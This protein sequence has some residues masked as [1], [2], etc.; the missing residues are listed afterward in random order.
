MTPGASRVTTTDTTRPEPTRGRTRAVRI[1]RVLLVAGA[2]LASFAAVADEV[3][4]A[5]GDRLTG[6]VVGK[7][8]G[9]LILDTAWAGEVKVRWDDV[10]SLRTDADVA[11][12]IDGVLV[13][14]R[15]DVA[16][17]PTLPTDA[18]SASREPP[19][20]AATF[21]RDSDG[22]ARRVPLATITF[23]NPTHAE[24]GDGIDWTGRLNTSGTFTRGNT[25][26][27]RFYGEG[28]LGGRS[29]DWRGS[30]GARGNRASE[31]SERTVSN[32]LGYADLDRFIDPR[33]YLYTRG[34]LE[35]DVF[36]DI[37]LRTTLGAGY[38]RQWIDT[39]ATQF[40]TQAGLDYLNVDR[41]AGVVDSYPSVGWGAKYTQWLLE[42]RL[43]LFHDQ[44]GFW[45]FDDGN[46]VTVRTRQ[47]LRMPVWRGF[48]LNVQLNVD[49]ESRPAE[50]RRA[51]DRV[52][53][54]GVGYQW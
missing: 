51:A 32:A 47:G 10:V 22:I 9:K 17:D 48:T 6:R 16:T 11:I 34:S 45:G 20:P 25:D 18:A 13:R 5:N 23:M 39:S 30:V 52:W 41:S 4:L 7:R 53:V 43:Q 14:G 35:S 2:A 27:T 46:R 44:T 1:A 33:R 26:A 29:K 19:L 21:T 49:W 12:V 40:S 28:E 54:F 24:S 3:R 50:G 15:L 42:R 36:R 8:D 38:G 31:A 37:N